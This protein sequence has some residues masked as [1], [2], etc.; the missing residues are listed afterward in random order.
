MYK[1]FSRGRSNESFSH[2][3]LLMAKLKHSSNKIHLKANMGE[4]A[5]ALLVSARMHESFTNLQKLS[6]VNNFYKSSKT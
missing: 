1:N 3:L 6:R 5:S 4:E 2:H